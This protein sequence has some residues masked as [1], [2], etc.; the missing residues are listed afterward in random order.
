MNRDSSAICNLKEKLAQLVSGAE[1]ELSTKIKI[2]KKNRECGETKI[3]CIQE[4]T[5]QESCLRGM[6]GMQS[7]VKKTDWAIGCDESN[8]IEDII[9]IEYS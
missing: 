6:K 4:Q 5:K 9:K 8:E 3:H 2:T 7:L 1:E